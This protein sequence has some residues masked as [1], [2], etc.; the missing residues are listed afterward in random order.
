MYDESISKQKPC[1][2]I[3]YLRKIR[4]NLGPLL[5]NFSNLPKDL[6]CFYGI[7]YKK[8]NLRTHVSQE[9]SILWRLM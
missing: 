6:M 1:L 5:K 8:R 4:H 7:L 9:T 3:N 2:V